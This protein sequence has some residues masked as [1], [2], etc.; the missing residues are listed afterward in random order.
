MC[1]ETGTNKPL[2]CPYVQLQTDAESYFHIGGL[3]QQV[4]H[5]QK[6]L[7]LGNLFDLV[8]LLPYPSIT[9]VRLHVL[10]VCL[11]ISQVLRH[12]NKKAPAPVWGLS[13]SHSHDSQLT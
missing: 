6:K 1:F 7:L 3:F 5:W 2:P 10:F 4:L 8:P 13:L 12:N 9:L 11:S